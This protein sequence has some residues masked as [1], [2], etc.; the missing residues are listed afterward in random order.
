MA[1][2]VPIR[3]GASFRPA[4]PC[5][6]VIKFLAEYLEEARR[7]E[8]TG[9]AISVV[10][11]IGSVTTDWAPGTAEQLVMLAGVTVLKHKIVSAIQ[12][13]D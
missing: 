7:G 8:I 5:E 12:D 2:V 11:P 1:D 9:V 10:R 3:D 4:E 13:A 6:E